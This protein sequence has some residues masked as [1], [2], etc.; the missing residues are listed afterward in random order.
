MNQ[1]GEGAWREVTELHR[2]EEET[3]FKPHQLV[4]HKISRLRGRTK[5]YFKEG[6]KTFLVVQVP[7]MKDKVA[8]TPDKWEKIADN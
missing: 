8:D 6:D 2:I 7:E 3:G 5:G 1:E 4:V